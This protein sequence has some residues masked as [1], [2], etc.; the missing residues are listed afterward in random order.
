MDE[1]RFSD[2]KLVEIE[3]LEKKYYNIYLK[4]LREK[5]EYIKEQFQKMNGRLELAESYQLENVIAIGFQE[6]I[7]S[8]FFRNTDYDVYML[9]TSSDTSF[10]SSDAILQ[11]DIKTIK[12]GDIR[13][14]DG[15]VIIP[16]P[17]Q[18]TYPGVNEKNSKQFRPALKT[19]IENKTYVT[20]F[21]RFIW[22]W[23]DK[24]HK[25]SSGIKISE[26]TLDSI[27]NGELEPIY[28]NLITGAKTYKY[29]PDTAKKDKIK[30]K[31]TSPYS[32]IDAARFTMKPEKINPKLTS[33]WTRR[34]KIFD[35]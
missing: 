12:S 6:L 33:D 9:P 3:E 1:K 4:I 16:H 11:I 8:I 21:V 13:G 7:R 15:M 31:E 17:N 20:F 23:V 28:G 35:W 25:H 19:Q 14:D 30:N 29:P 24:D 2:K 18:C 10:E 26:F 32:I 5:E 27:P 22:E 34:T